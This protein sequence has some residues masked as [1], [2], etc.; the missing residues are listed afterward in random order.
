VNNWLNNIPNPSVSD[1]DLKKE[2]ISVI[3]S[4]EFSYGKYLSEVLPIFKRI[5]D[6][7][8]EKQDK[9]KKKNNGDIYFC[10]LNRK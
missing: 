2:I 10:V 1:T 3:W 4:F 6:M 7:N 5:D 9:E 8:K